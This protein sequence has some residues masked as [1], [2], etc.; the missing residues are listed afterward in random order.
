[1]DVIFWHF[2]LTL[3]L[4]QVAMLLRHMSYTK[5]PFTQSFI[6]TPR[7]H[8]HHRELVRQQQQQKKPHQKENYSK[9]NRARMERRINHSYFVTVILREKCSRAMLILYW[10]WFDIEKWKL[11]HYWLFLFSFSS[12]SS[13]CSSLELLDVYVNCICHLHHC[14][15]TSI[16]LIYLKK[17]IVDANE[18]FIQISYH[19]H[20]VYPQKIY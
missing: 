4:H 16:F 5:V 11:I 1:M 14:R 19:R 7:H 8:Q 2:L 12:T 10:W 18:N 9:Q 15:S 6:H 20:W 13:W 3:H 17:T